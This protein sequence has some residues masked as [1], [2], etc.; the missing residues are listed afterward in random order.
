M[1]YF[2]FEYQAP[3]PLVS[4]LI[5]CL[6]EMDLLERAISS[7]VN[8]NYS[9]WEIVVTL[10]SKSKFTHEE[11]S[12][13]LKRS[14]AWRRTSVIKSTR[15]GG[16][17][18]TRNFGLDFCAGR[19]VAFLD[20]D[21]EF[22]EDKLVLQVRL[23]E[24]LSLDFSHTSYFALNSTSKKQRY[25]STS[26]MTGIFIQRKLVSRNSMIATPTVMLSRS[27]LLGIDHL[28]D[29]GLNQGED[30]AAWIRLLKNSKKPVGHLDVGLSIVHVRPDSLQRKNR[31]EF[32]ELRGELRKIQKRK[33]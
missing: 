13:R 4:V 29:E 14:P 25:I 15:K 32:S 6:D 7:V 8:Q 10:D 22:C 17:G 28:F 23:M 5:P 3:L 20:A 19:Y 31:T 26:R 27:S 30:T 33:N 9:N 2:N 24:T 12:S 18:P 1:R 21:D 11:V 16:A